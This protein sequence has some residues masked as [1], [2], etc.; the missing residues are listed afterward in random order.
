MLIN[1]TLKVYPIPTV[2]PAFLGINSTSAE[3]LQNNNANFF[4]AVAYIHTQLPQLSTAGLMG[5]YSIMPL[6][7]SPGVAP[8]NFDFLIYALSSSSSAVNTALQPLM[9][10][11]SDWTGITTSL[12]VEQP[13]TFAVFRATHLVAAP[14][15]TKY[16]AG[17]RLWDKKAV[18]D[19]AGVVTVLQA[20]Q[21]Q[22]LEGTF[23]SGPGVQNIPADE[24]SVNPAWRRTVVELSES[25]I[26]IKA[27]AQMQFK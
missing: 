19:E 11:L 7:T 24:S 3:A 5:Y 26:P 1:A 15:G 12:G 6:S 10:R 8:M 18:Q 9:T 25:I 13:M 22:Y 14:V 2:A 20:F 4:S 17:N 23:V 21:N 16:L 27:Y